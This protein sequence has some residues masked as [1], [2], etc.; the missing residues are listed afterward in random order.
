MEGNLGA[1]ASS[2]RGATSLASGLVSAEVK[3]LIHQAF[4]ICI[5]K[6]QVA[7]TD[8]VIVFD[9]PCDGISDLTR[10]DDHLAPLG[11]YLGGYLRG[12]LGGRGT[13]VAGGRSTIEGAI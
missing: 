1:T 4:S 11:L 8:K 12:R 5:G 3:V 10:G 9:S 7:D 6:Q 13:E 2:S